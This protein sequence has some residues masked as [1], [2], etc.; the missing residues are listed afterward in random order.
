MT[1]ETAYP[2]EISP[3]P[4]CL[5]CGGATAFALERRG[6]AIVRCASCGFACAP[7]AGAADAARLYAEDEFFFAGRPETAQRSW[8]DVLWTRKRPFY[9][10]RLDRIAGFARPARVLDI[11]CAGGYLMRAARERGWSVEGVEPSPAMRERTRAA[12]GCPVYESVE[13]ARA[14]GGNF[15]CVMM[16][17]V[18][19]HLADPVAA[20]RAIR[21]L[22]APNGVLALSTPNCDA[23]GAI[24][25]KP[26]DIWFVPPI[27]V[28]F[29][30]PATLVRC[31][32]RAGFAAIASAGIE[33][34][35]GVLA[36]EI[37]LPRWLRAA[38][39]PLRRGKRLLPH[40]AIGKLIERRYAGR[41]DLYQ[42]RDPAGIARADV[43]E[44]YARRVD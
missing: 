13:Q 22:L 44:L 5:L 19:E 34:F 11:G 1:T 10:A 18:I 4:R 25:G 8:Y 7:A 41:I 35:A 32:E 37:R 2:N 43:L 15:D 42:R 3:A 9:L 39:K 29:F 30:N 27:H 6:F 33:G 12:L 20:L 40:G 28:S 21:D 16:F 36:G 31:V 17:E 14:A 38:L 26:L 24:D 23:P